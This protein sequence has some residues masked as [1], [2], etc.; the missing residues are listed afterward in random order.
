MT[1][2]IRKISPYAVEHGARAGVLPSLIIAQ[3]ILESAHGTSELAVNARNLFGIKTGVGWQGAVYRKKTAEYVNG[4][5]VEVMAE[6]RAYPTYEGAVIDLVAKY[7]GMARYAAVPFSR[8]YK[9]ATQAVFAAG[10]ATDPQYP[11]KLNR[12]IEQYGLTKYDEGV[13]R[14][15]SIKKQLVTSRANVSAGTNTR[16]Y[17]TIHETA[18]TSRG[19]NAQSHANLH[20]RGNT[21]T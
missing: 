4:K 18:N 15:V 16:E 17:N 5:R 14:M 11:A 10:Y 6:F 7:T 20:S 19:A 2:F 3:G 21:R 1:N 13:A 9:A 8:D 12:I